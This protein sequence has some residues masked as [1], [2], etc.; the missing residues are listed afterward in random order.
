MSMQ[1]P[2]QFVWYYIT[3]QPKNGFQKLSP[4]PPKSGVWNLMRNQS[5]GFVLLLLCKFQIAQNIF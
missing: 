3:E 1:Y 2:V 4:D 5:F